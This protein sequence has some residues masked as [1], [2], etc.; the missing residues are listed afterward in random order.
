M[1]MHHEGQVRDTCAK[2]HL[3]NFH[4]MLRMRL[5]PLLLL[6]LLR[7]PLLIWLLMCQ[8][9][10]EEVGT[11]L[12]MPVAQQMCVLRRQQPPPNHSSSNSKPDNAARGS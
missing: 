8:T 4:Q 1:G 3:D 5:L 10:L 12:T 2:P 6:L 9:Q 7:W 11:Q